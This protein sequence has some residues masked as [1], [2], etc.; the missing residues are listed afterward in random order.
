M[1]PIIVVLYGIGFVV[2][3]TTRCETLLVYFQQEE[4]DNRRFLAAWSSVRLYDVVASGLALLVLSFGWIFGGQNWGLLALAGIFIVIALQE[5]RY[6]YKKPLVNTER[7]RRLRSV[8]LLLLVLLAMIATLVPILTLVVLQLVPVALILANQLLQPAQ[9]RV[10]SGFIDE[11]LQRLSESSAIPIGVTG[12]FGKTTV[13]HMLAEM[14]SVGGPVFYSRGSVNTVLG[15]TRHIRQRL[16]PAHKYFVA[17][18]GAYQIGSIDRLCHFVKP[19]Y[20]VVTAVGE[21]H[22]E[23]FG[24]IENTAKAKAELAKWVCQ[25]GERLITT[26][27]VIAHPPFAGLQQQFPQKFVVVGHSDSS[28]VKVCQAELVDGKWHIVLGFRGSGQFSYTLPLLGEHNILNSALAVA[29]V[30]C[31]DSSLLPRLTSKISELEQ[32]AHRLELKQNEGEPLVLDD[33]YNSNEQGFLNAVTVLRNLTDERGGRAVLVTPGIAELGVEHDEI[34]RRL[35]KYCAELCDVVV[36]VN[37]D[38][39]PTF[40]NELESAPAELLKAPSLVDARKA[41]RYLGLSNA[42]VV[43]YENDLPDLLEEK[44]LL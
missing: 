6:Q 43:L 25:H 5:R 26:E 20:G 23:R 42:D 1:E 28:D 32:V 2:L 38:R 16:Q 13:K 10:N 21:A 36:A 7:V 27:A 34:H 39:I 24:G 15:L 35:G 31:V 41:L 17:E 37:A 22:A 4:Y 8:S 44:R 29:L 18:M 19:V 12:S 40:V 3:L 9:Q 14:L 30:H 33:A 11:A